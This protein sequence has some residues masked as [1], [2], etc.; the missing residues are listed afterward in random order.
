MWTAEERHKAVLFEVKL[1]ELESAYF[2]YRR[3][4]GEL[5]RAQWQGWEDY[6]RDW[7][8]Y[9]EFRTAW[10][11]GLADEFDQ[12]FRDFVEREIKPYLPT[13][14]LEGACELSR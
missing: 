11:R 8:Q 5:D 12:V 13:V 4:K 3:Q 6:I 7:M 9:P 1:C 10:D 14:R 2:Q